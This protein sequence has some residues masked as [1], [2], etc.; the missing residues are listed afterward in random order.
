[1][2]A[3]FRNLSVRSH[4]VLAHAESNMQLHSVFHNAPARNHQFRTD[5]AG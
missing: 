5:L 3:V 4:A 2:S 1:M